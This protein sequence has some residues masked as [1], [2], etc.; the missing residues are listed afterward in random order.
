MAPWILSASPFPDTR[1]FCRAVVAVIFIRYADSMIY[2]R[3][4]YDF[5][6]VYVDVVG[7]MLLLRFFR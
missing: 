3:Y 7:Y 5:L 4:L 6:V 1:S 2:L